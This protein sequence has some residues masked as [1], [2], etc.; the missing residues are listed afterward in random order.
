MGELIFMDTGLKVPVSA[1]S[2]ETV[3]TYQEIATPNEIRSILQ[4]GTVEGTLTCT[5]SIDT[6]GLLT[7]LMGRKITNNW[8][9]MHGGVLRRKR[10]LKL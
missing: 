1:C 3:D 7:L 4:G 8:L 10:G 5:L 9:K 6:L 2:I